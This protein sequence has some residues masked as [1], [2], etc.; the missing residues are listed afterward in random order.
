METKKNIDPNILKNI[1]NMK[2]GVAGLLGFARTLI[3]QKLND[4]NTSETEKEA[5]RAQLKNSNLDK[6]EG[7][8]EK[9]MND[10]KKKMSGH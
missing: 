10:L 8:L 4:P 1:E 2:S 7:D 9:A 3:D 5:I 6:A